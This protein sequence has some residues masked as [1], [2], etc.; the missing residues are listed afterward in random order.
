MKSK[1]IYSLDLLKF[2][3]SI[4]IIVLHLQQ[5]TMVGTSVINLASGKI[6]TWYI[7]ELFFIISGF[8]SMSSFGSD[9]K[10]ESTIKNGFPLYF[11]HKAIRIY[12]MAV[13]SILFTVFCGVLYRI[14]FGSWLHNIVPSLWRIFKTLVLFNGGFLGSDIIYGSTTWY[15]SVLLLCYCLEY[16]LIYLCKRLSL[17][18]EYFFIL[19]ILLGITGYCCGT[20]LPLLSYFTS[21]GYASFFIGCMIYKAYNNQNLKRKKLLTYSIIVF[22][23]CVISWIINFD[24]FYDDEICQWGVSTVLLWPSTFIIFLEL[25]RWFKSSMWQVLGDM[26]FEMY[27]WHMPFITLYLIFCDIFPKNCLPEMLL[28]SLFIVF[29]VIFSFIVFTFVEKPINKKFLTDCGK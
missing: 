12:P 14:Y 16:F 15:L 6:Y 4:I 21:R 2:F 27:L 3:V 23:I 1:R 24:L 9:E 25:S 17:K 20:N 28:L 8:L 29:M 22:F 11:K 26:S 13:L 5:E 7:V 10:V 18:I 19:M